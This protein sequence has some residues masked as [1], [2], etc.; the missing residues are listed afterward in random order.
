LGVASL[1]VRSKVQRVESH[2]FYRALGFI[3]LKTQVV[4]RKTP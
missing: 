4:Y 2:D 1:L 3:S